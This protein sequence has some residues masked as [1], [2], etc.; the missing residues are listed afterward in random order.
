M[1]KSLYTILLALLLG[2]SAL[3]GS[4]GL[5]AQT[6][7]DSLSIDGPYILHKG[8]S[9][10][11]ITVSEEGV[12]MDTTYAQAPA[13]FRVCDHKGRYPF[14]MS[15]RRIERQD[16][17]TRATPERVF[18]MSDPHG[19]LDCVIS[20]LQGN[21]VIDEDLHWAYG[22]DQLV[23]IGDIFDRGDDAVQIFWFF[24]RLQQEAAEAGGKVTML[25]GNHEPMEFSGDMR[26]ATP[27]YPI[28][29]RELGVEYR[30]LFGPDSELGRWIASWNIIGIIGRD[31]YVHAGLSGEFYREDIPIEEVNEEMSNAI[32]MRSKERKATS[33]RLK[34][35]Y[36][37]RGPIWYRGMVLNGKRWNPVSNDT[38]NL[39][40]SRYDIDHIVVGHTIFNDVRAFRNGRVIC[41]NVDNARNRKKGLGRALLIEQGR[42]YVVG[43]KGKLRELIP[44]R[45]R[46]NK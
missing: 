17:C 41:V 23:Q 21:G 14:N 25:M 38:L 30:D 34:F 39:I 37:G 33:E 29:A 45:S 20:L 7:R 13:S 32:F 35:L 15:L 18:V 9:I 2:A 5:W 22:S 42:Y 24:Y 3:T 1:R 46:L 10:R 16:W 40:L 31:L 28:L 8:D 19:K 26:Y 36:G 27:K 4:A 43:D 44:C 6:A 11:V 12:I